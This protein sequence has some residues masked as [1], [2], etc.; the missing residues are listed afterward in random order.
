MKIYNLKLL[1]ILEK[2]MGDSATE[3]KTDMRGAMKKIIDDTSKMVMRQ[4]NEI[5][6]MSEE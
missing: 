6:Q 5:I 4:C 3:M 1:L 2:K